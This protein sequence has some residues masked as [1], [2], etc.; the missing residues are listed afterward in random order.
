[1]SGKPNID[2][3]GRTMTSRRQRV[4]GLGDL[5]GDAT[6]DAPRRSLAMDGELDRAALT[7]YLTLPREKTP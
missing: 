4:Q 6:T 1:M 3:S 5:A 7:A 2:E